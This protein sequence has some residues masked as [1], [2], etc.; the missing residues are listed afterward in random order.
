MHPSIQVGE[1][2][3]THT[4]QPTKMCR[5]TCRVLRMEGQRSALVCTCKI[6]K[7]ASYSLFVTDTLCLYRAGN[8][9]GPLL[10]MEGRMIGINTAIFTNTGVSAGVGFAIPINTVNNIVPQLI[11]FGKVVRPSLKVQFAKD[12]VARQFSVTNGALA[13]FV[14][15][16]SNAG[17]AGLLPTRRSLGGIVP[18]DVVTAIDGR[19]VRNEAD[20]DN[21]LDEYQVGEVVVLTVLRGVETDKPEKLSLEIAL[22]ESK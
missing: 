11:K 9:G 18:G 2:I 15:E 3:R 13:Q 21:Y 7:G 16:K 17:K 19:R 20:I 10:D 8:S 1:S 22:E 14:D 12:N 5:P 6:M 4:N